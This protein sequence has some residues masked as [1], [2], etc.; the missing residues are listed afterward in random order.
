MGVLCKWLLLM[1][2]PFLTFSETSM[3]TSKEIAPAKKPRR[4]EVARVSPEAAEVLPALQHEEQLRDCELL[5]NPQP[6][7]RYRSLNERWN[8]I[9]LLNPDPAH[10]LAA[11]YPTVIMNNAQLDWFVVNSYPRH[12]I[13]DPAYK[14]SEFWYYPLISAGVKEAGYRQVIGHYETVHRALI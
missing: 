2:V 6:M 5:L 1:A 11:V 13:K 7:A 9:D 3:G 10:N 14:R 8:L 4:S 12:R